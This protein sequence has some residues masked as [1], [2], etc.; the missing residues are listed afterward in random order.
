MS[1]P[2]TVQKTVARVLKS[3]R[4]RGE[5]TKSGCVALVMN[6]LSRGSGGYAIPPALVHAASKHIIASEVDRQLKIGLP[7]NIFDKALR[8]APPELVQVLPKLPAWI[9]TSEGSDA[10]WV[11]S[12]QASAEDWMANAS[13][14]GKKARQTMRKA[15]TSADISR[16]LSEY[17]ISNLSETLTVN[18][19]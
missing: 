4:R 15:N 11:P 8:N 6:S 5:T 9:A 14:K 13:M 7:P 19:E 3:E 2:Q 18:Q 16:Y 10:R 17:G 12:L 1:T